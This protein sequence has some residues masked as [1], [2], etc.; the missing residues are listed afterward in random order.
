MTPS[1]SKPHG[2]G[3]SD[4]DTRTGTGDDRIRQQYE[5]LPYPERRPAD[6]DK[7]LVTGSPSHLHEVDHHLFGGQLARRRETFRVLVAGGGTGDA[8]IMLAQQCADAG[9]DARFTYVDPSSAAGEVAR[10]RAA[11]RGL[12]DRISFLQGGLPDLPLPDD[13]QFDYI[14]CCGVLHHLSDPT[15]CLGALRDR[16]APGG[17]MGIMVY[18]TYG[19]TGVYTLQSALDRMGIR[20]LTPADA[21]KAARRVLNALP[22]SNWLKLNPFVGD[23]KISDAGLY[24]LLLHSRDRSYTVPAFLDLISGA[25]LEPVTMMLPAAYDPAALLPD[26]GLKQRWQDLPLREQAALAEEIAGGL[27]VHIAYL[28][29]A[30]ETQGRQARPTGDMVPVLKDN[31]GKEIAK[32]TR[33]GT[34]LGITIAGLRL[35]VSIPALGPAILSRIDGMRTIDA[36]FDDIAASRGGRLDRDTFDRDMAAVVDGFAGIGRLHLRAAGTDAG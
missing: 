4:A 17:G 35:S 29:R 20:D 1:D 15:A 32:A 33:P 34:P 7:R 26:A 2:V 10:K 11:R 18:G 12:D 25:G 22:P 16:L 27:K 8:L 3:G 19:R 5:S 28:A 23:H 31:D 13:A 9:I 36:L 24:D 21:V 14:D 6:E 30:G